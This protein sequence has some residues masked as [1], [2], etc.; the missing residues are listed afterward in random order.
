MMLQFPQLY[1]G[2][3]KTYLTQRIIVR[4]ER[5]TECKEH[6][7]EPSTWHTQR[8]LFLWFHSL[9]LFLWLP[10]KPTIAD[11]QAPEGIISQT[12]SEHHMGHPQCTYE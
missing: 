11:F 7:M 8:L 10:A 1:H 12:Y 3:N 9:L 5:D 2:H 6:G 4:T